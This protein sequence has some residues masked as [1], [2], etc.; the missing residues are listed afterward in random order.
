MRSLASKA[1]EKA[2]KSPFAPVVL[3]LV[4]LVASLVRWG[5]QGSGNLYTTL[6]KRL[7][8]PDRDLGWRIAD[9]HPIWLG[10]EVCA[11]IAAIAVGI[12]I[13][14][15]LVRRIR[16]TRPTLAK[17]MLVAAWVV[18]ALTPIVPIAAFASGGRIEGARDTLPDRT[19]QTAQVGEG[20]SGSLDLPKGRYDVVVHSGS[21]ITA[22]VKAG[23]ESFDARFSGDLRGTFLA[24]PGNLEAPVGGRVTVSAASV[25]TG[26]RPRS[27]SARDQYLQA[28]K[29]PEI[30]FELDE[31]VA[32]R[33]EAPDRVAFRATGRLELI[34]KTHVVEVTG[35]LSKP[36]E[37]ALA[38][39]GL[40]GAILLVQADFSIAIKDTAL[41]PDA[42]DF[43]VDRIPIHVSLVLRHAGDG[44]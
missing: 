33:E 10:L 32:A 7:Y 12:A 30:A 15:W 31:L 4:A 36:D 41:A 43:D 26:V 35:T 28:A 37:A 29:Y 8:V 21:S 14:G 38:R 42:G 19:E 34:G 20:I 16:S 22:R 39:L 5:L 17:T 6:D 27:N 24:D 25:D 18:G 1:T 2:V 9:H 44:A 40:T 3:P 11:I 13:G 23:G